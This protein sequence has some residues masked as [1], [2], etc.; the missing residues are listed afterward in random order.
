MTMKL[1]RKEYSTHNITV[2][3]M[4]GISIS[5]M[6][7]CLS[8][9]KPVW[10]DDQLYDCRKENLDPLCRWIDDIMTSTE[11]YSFADKIWYEIIVNELPDGEVFL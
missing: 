10:I 4:Y 5:I 8:V 1:T 9:R 11:R 7:K 6:I 2:S 3:T